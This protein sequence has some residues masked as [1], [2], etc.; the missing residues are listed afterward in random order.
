MNRA[1]TVETW[2]PADFKTSPLKQNSN[3]KGASCYINSTQTNSGLLLNNPEI[4]SWGVGEF[5]NE[6]THQIKYSL[7]LQFSDQLDDSVTEKK[8][9]AENLLL[10]KLKEFDDYMIDHACKNIKTWFPDVIAETPNFDE[11]P[12][13]MVKMLIKQKYTPSIRYPKNKENPKLKDYTKPPSFNP[14]IGLY[15]GVWKIKIFD[16]E[17]VANLLFPRETNEPLV[18]ENGELIVDETGNPIQITPKTFIHPRTRL[19]SQVNASIWVVAGKFGVKWS[20]K[21][22]RVKPNNNLLSLNTNC[23]IPIDDDDIVDTAPSKT[24]VPKTEY[25]I[26]QLI[27]ED[28][29]PEKEKEKEK[30]PEQQQQQQ[31]TLEPEP[32]VEEQ[33]VVKTAV[34]RVIK[35]NVK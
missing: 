29:E 12:P 25:K 17:K 3:G 34:K 1:L 32:V 8:R 4:F 23:T 11:L 33:P 18:D 19:Y 27:D 16:T 21:E 30:E 20:V 28:D 5:E 31:P 24:V 22:V 2:N 15:N 14:T 10:K 13:E 9:Q 6:Q 7:S 26:P 35:K